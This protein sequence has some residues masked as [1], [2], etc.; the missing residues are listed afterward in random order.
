MERY[1]QK[2]ARRMCLFQ[3]LGDKMFVEDVT[4]SEEDIEVLLNDEELCEEFLKQL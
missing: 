1:N 2:Q 4:L 3:Y